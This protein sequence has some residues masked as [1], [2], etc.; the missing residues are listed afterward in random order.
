M[1]LL[2]LFR[3]NW[4]FVLPYGLMLFGL[5]IYQILY[6]QGIIALEINRYYSS[7]ADLFFKYFTHLGDGVFCISAGVLL[8]LWAR[9]K[10]ILVLASYAISGI[11]AQLIKNFGFP[12]EPRPVEYFAGMI[13]SLHTVPGV[14]LAHWHS[15]PSGHTTSGFAFFALIAVWVRPP[16]LKLLCLL[17][18]TTVAFSRMYLL[19]HFLVDVYAGS[20]LGTLTA[21][22]L[23]LK[24][25]SKDKI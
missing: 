12:K 2:K 23:F 25:G 18:A 4:A 21:W 6:R 11:L 7:Q 8:L 15:F 3:A 22:G 19:Q 10:G 20:I 17:A 1:S 14:E 13:D 9:Y 16:L 24:F 5:G